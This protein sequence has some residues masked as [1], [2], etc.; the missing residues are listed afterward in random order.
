M[1]RSTHISR[2]NSA[3]IKLI[4]T[5]NIAVVPVC[6]SFH[7]FPIYVTSYYLL[8][9][10]SSLLAYFFEIRATSR[11][12][13][14]TNHPRSR[15]TSI[16]KWYTILKLKF[17]SLSIWNLIII[18]IYP[19]Y[20]SRKIDID[21]T[22]ICLELSPTGRRPLLWLRYRHPSTNSFYN[23]SIKDSSNLSVDASIQDIKGNFNYSTQCLRSASE[24]YINNS[25]S[26]LDL[27]L[28]NDTHFTIFSGSAHPFLK[29]QIRFQSHF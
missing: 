7:I 22:G 13:T 3:D 1:V 10:P 17:D 6:H 24:I 25:T 11:L 27:L 4:A 21:V 29:K 5:A 14:L 8:P 15:I 12:A 9:Y 28:V 19:L 2:W 20:S 18:I 23:N 26:I 16:R